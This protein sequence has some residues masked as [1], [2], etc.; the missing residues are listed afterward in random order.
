MNKQKEARGQPEK[1]YKMDLE[2]RDREI[3][4]EPPTIS[5]GRIQEKELKKWIAS[6]F[7]TVTS[8]AFN[9]YSKKE[10]N[11]QHAKIFCSENIFK[12]IT[13]L[14]RHYTLSAKELSIIDHHVERSVL[15]YL[16][17][18]YPLTDSTNINKKLEEIIH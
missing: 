1:H 13:N 17:T 4:I 8:A 5:N 16:G 14:S 9:Y 15:N 7:K 12:N 3:V 11:F 6:V 2:P 18:K 10:M